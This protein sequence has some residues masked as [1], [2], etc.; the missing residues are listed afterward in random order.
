MSESGTYLTSMYTLAGIG[1]ILVSILSFIGLCY[2]LYSQGTAGESK[3]VIDTNYFLLSTADIAFMAGLWFLLCSGVIWI[4]TIN[5]PASVWVIIGSQWLL[6]AY[7]NATLKITPEDAG[8]DDTR[9]FIVVWTFALPTLV[10]FI[11]LAMF[12]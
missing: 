3:A 1:L 4:F 7:N 2:R 5:H 11:T 8:K 9:F 10:W 6:V 12:R